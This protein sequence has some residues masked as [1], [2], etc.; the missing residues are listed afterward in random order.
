[1][2]T[3]TSTAS[4][5]TRAAARPSGAASTA[6]PPKPGAGLIDSDQ[7]ICEYPT[8]WR[9]YTEG[10][11]RHLCI[12]LEQDS[13]GYGWITGGDGRRIYLAEINHPADTRRMAEHRQR[14]KQG[15]PAEVPFAE[16]LTPEMWDPAARVRFLAESGLDRSVVFPNYGLLWERALG[17]DLEALT[18]NMSAW[19]RRAADIVTASDDALLPVG[20]VTLRDLEWLDRELGELAGGGVHFAMV[21]PSLV[22][23]LPLSHPDLDRAWSSFV[24]HGVCPVFHIAAFP[25]FPFDHAWFRDIPDPIDSPL[26]SV[27]LSTAPALAL[28][29]LVLHGT[30]ERHPDLRLGIVEFMA[31]WL[32]QYLAMLDGGFSYYQAFHG[33][34]YSKLSLRP[35]EYVKQHVRVAAFSYED[36]HR[37]TE[38]IGADILMFGSDYPHAEGVARPLS[39]YMSQA[40]DD[41][42]RARGGLYGDNVMWLA[43]GTG[44]ADSTDTLDTGTAT[45]TG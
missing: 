19:N 24:D 11:R 22:D 29:D 34:P 38:E 37:L 17:D 4:T 13:L 32:V 1:M 31:S 5:W 21:A 25:T 20:H 2:T 30:F 23:G 43:T 6:P 16:A 45:G 36:P 39:D 15:K 12:S 9:D 3:T 7:H 33:E 18:V 44:G 41:G 42:S 8:M 28:A 27:F 10:S 35:S 40:G 14:L 26:S